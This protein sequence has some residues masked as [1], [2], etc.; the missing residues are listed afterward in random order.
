MTTVTP[1]TPATPRAARVAHA[2]RLLATRGRELAAASLRMDGPAW[3]AMLCTEGLAVPDDLGAVDVYVQPSH[4]GL[5]LM[6]QSVRVTAERLDFELAGRDLS[7]DR[8]PVV[9]AHRLRHAVEVLDEHGDELTLL[10]T[11]RTTTA[12]AWWRHLFDLRLAYARPDGVVDLYVRPLRGRIG[13]GHAVRTGRMITWMMMGARRDC[14]R[15]TVVYAELCGPTSPDERVECVDGDDLNCQ[16][17]NLRT[18]PRTRRRRTDPRAARSL[19]TD[20]TSRDFF[21]DLIAIGALRLDET[22]HVCL[23]GQVHRGGH[24][25]GEGWRRLS[26]APSHKGRSRYVVGTGGRR[27]TIAQDELVTMV[28][29]YQRLE[30]RRPIPAS[31]VARSEK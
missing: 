22:G 7:A 31:A 19:T 9:H 17:A 11:G 14:R 28:R 5:G 1:R 30:K 3:W 20:A 16:A 8:W 6:V 13:A 4:I 27:F 12:A 23:A 25:N 10:A 26:L 2:E 18:A 21:L 24:I 29:L 15:S